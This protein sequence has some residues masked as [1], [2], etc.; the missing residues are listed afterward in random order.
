MS[1]TSTAAELR[2]RWAKNTA[3]WARERATQGQLTGSLPSALWA[4]DP[5]LRKV[6]RYSRHSAQIRLGRDHLRH[7]GVE[8]GDYLRIVLRKDGSL[9]VR[10]VSARELSQ[11]QTRARLTIFSGRKGKQ[12]PSCH[13]DTTASRTT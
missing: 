7:L 9:T 11:V 6:S 12:A 8:I 3:T 5:D 4:F 1:K 2:E 10:K 13:Y